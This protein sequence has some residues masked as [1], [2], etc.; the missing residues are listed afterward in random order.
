MASGGRN[1]PN[2]CA[3]TENESWSSNLHTHEHYVHILIVI[4]ALYI[5]DL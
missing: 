3:E 2:V 5:I 4:D 1:F